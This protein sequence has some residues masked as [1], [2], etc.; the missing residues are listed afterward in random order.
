M[1]PAIALGLRMLLFGLLQVL[2]LDSFRLEPIAQLHGFLLVLLLFPTQWSMGLQLSLA[3]GY[4]LL[5]DQ[6]FGPPGALALAATWLVGLRLWW[7][8]VITPPITWDG[9]EELP[10]A[11]QDLGWLL[12][13]MLPLVLVYELV[14]FGLVDW[15]I[16]WRGLLKSL[17]TGVYSAVFA[18]LVLVLAFRKR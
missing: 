11:Q 9:D 8:R 17:A 3:F 2:L 14:Y 18:L 10:I 4:G 15:A 13:Y 5:L 12:R 16:S 7:L 1:S 6:F